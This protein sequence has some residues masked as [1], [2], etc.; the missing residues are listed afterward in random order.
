MRKIIFLLSFYLAVSF[1]VST[2]VFGQADKIKDRAAKTEVLQLKKDVARFDSI[3]E[4]VVDVQNAVNGIEIPDTLQFVID[5]Q[6]LSYPIKD[7]KIIIDGAIQFYK[8]NKGN[9]PKDAKSWLALLFTLAAGGKLTQYIVSAKRVIATLKPLFKKT[10]Y[11]VGFVALVLSIG[12]TYLWGIINGDKGFDQ[13]VY[14]FISTAFGFLAVLI[15]ENWIKPK[16]TETQTA[17][18]P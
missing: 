5:G 8:E 7:G 6:T 2:D 13:T 16:Q 1:T 14:A 17:A 11:V 4:A 10:I 9:W 18:Q 12:A 15:Y 3:A